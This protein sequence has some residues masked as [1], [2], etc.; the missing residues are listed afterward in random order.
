MRRLSQFCAI[1]ALLLA[2][3]GNVSAD[4]RFYYI[5]TADAVI[6]GQLRLSSYFLWFDGLHVNGS[7]VATEVL[8]GGG[9]E[10]PAFVYHLVVPCSVWDAISSRCDYRAAWQHRDET[11]KIFTRM[12]IWALVK[13]PGASWTS[14][15][16]RAPCVYD[17]ADREKVIA[18]LKTRPASR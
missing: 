8:Y 16:S 2:L 10:G 18:I 12:Q 7:I 11:K 13:G 17:L 3:G 15:L 14:G 9:E 1:A 6:V 4:E 5:R